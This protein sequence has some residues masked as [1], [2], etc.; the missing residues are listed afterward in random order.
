MNIDYVSY[1]SQTTQ[2][3]FMYVQKKRAQKL[4][5]WINT[6]AI[7]T[8]HVAVNDITLTLRGVAQLSTHHSSI[9]ASPGVITHSTPLIVHADLHSAFICYITSN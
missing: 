7:A 9:R 6:Y 1:N 3:V 5:M 2:T 4:C 8:V